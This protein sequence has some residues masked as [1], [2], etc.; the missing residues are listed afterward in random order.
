MAGTL[1]RPPRM[2]TA[3]SWCAHRRRL[4]RRDAT[5]ARRHRHAAERAR[6]AKRKRERAKAKHFLRA[7]SSSGFAAAIFARLRSSRCKTQLSISH[8]LSSA[9]RVFFPRVGVRGNTPVR[10]EQTPSRKPA[11]HSLPLDE[12][13]MLGCVAGWECIRGWSGWLVGLAVA[14]VCAFVRVCFRVCVRSCVR[15]VAC[16]RASC[17]GLRFCKATLHPGLLRGCWMETVREW[18]G[19][20]QH[21]L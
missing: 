3:A 18:V 10:S 15:F 21:H 16:S 20:Y 5:A 14:L 12:F 13:K 7:P 8:D 11:G 6:G 9:V 2:S 17:P 1:L 19:S 4:L